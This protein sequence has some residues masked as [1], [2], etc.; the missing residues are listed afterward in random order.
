MFSALP[1]KWPWLRVCFLQAIWT[2]ALPTTLQISPSLCPLFFLIPPSYVFNLGASRS[3]KLVPS[4]NSRELFRQLLNCIYMYPFL[5]LSKILL[6]QKFPMEGRQLEH[7]IQLRAVFYY[8]FHCITFIPVCWQQG[9][10]PL[11]PCAAGCLR[12][13]SGS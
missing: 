9:E 13:A 10:I 5:S 2:C 3:Q 7:G 1:N 4:Q 6:V 11:C 8:S 12:K